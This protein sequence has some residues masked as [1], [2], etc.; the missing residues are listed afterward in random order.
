MAVP[1]VTFEQAQ[2]MF[3]RHGLRSWIGSLGLA[4]TLLGVSAF[5]LRTLLPSAN[6]TTVALGL[7]L[8]V[9]VVATLSSLAIAAVMSLAAVLVFNFFFIPPVGTFTVADPR[10]WVALGTFL[11]VGLV[12]SRLSTLARSRAVEATAR[13]DELARLFDLG[14]DV[15]LTTDSTEALEGLARHVARRFGLK[16]VTLYLPG[17]NGWHV[18]EGG[19]EAHQIDRATLADVFAG[20]RGPLEFDARQRTYAGQRDVPGPGG[21][22]V[23]LVPV[24]IGT[25]VVGLLAASGRR[26]DASALDAL[27]GLVAIAIERAAFLEERKT[28]EMNRQ[29]ADLAEALLASFSHDL[30]SPLTAIKVAVTNL[31]NADLDPAARDEQARLAEAETERLARLL[32]DVLDMARIDARALTIEPAWVTPAAI[33]DAAAAQLA[34]QLRNHRLDL[35]L[36]ED[37]EVHVDPR[38]AASALGHVLENAVQYSPAG[39]VVHV[40]GEASAGQLRMI[41]RDEG[42]G[43][44]AADLERLFDRFFR[45]E[46]AKRRS[47]GTGMGLA[48]TRGLLAAHG[49]RIW[50]ENVPPHGAQFTFVIPAEARAGRAPAAAGA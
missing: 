2:R 12:A 35:H 26:V 18:H 16:R 7:L 23:H 11:V 10:N 19:R 46:D 39:S 49:G 32:Q 34:A 17:A 41:V 30:R 50:A 14:R 6:E 27:A 40:R 5:L 28:S 37:T 3:E 47:A 8:V 45:G 33:V 48:I 25:R 29:R 4:L 42:P 15:L 31:R 9:L 20:G 24:R 43:L 1:A 38:I 22:T 44:H 21:E 36:D 13:R